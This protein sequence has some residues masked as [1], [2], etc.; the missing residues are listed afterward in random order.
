MRYLVHLVTGQAR[1]FSPVP[2]HGIYL[3]GTPRGGWLHRIPQLVNAAGLDGQN[4]LCE[5]FLVFQGVHYSYDVFSLPSFL[6][7]SRDGSPP[8]RHGPD[9]LG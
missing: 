3:V 5:S 1:R 2:Y 4:F 9:G 7:L 6:A 8:G